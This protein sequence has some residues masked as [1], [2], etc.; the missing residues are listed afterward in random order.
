MEESAVYSVGKVLGLDFPGGT[1]VSPPE[2][3]QILGTKAEALIPSHPS[4]PLSRIRTVVS[5]S[6]IVISVGPSLA[7]Q[8]LTSS[9][10]HLLSPSA[11]LFPLHRQLSPRPGRLAYHVVQFLCT[12]PPMKAMLGMFIKAPLGFA[13][14]LFSVQWP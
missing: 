1:V 3:P 7:G 11:S 2:P 13:A 8:P 9:L 10:C 5:V 14:Q 4:P 12:V 6:A